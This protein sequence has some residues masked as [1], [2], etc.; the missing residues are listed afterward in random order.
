M[1]ASVVTLGATHQQQCSFQQQRPS[2]CTFAHVR[3]TRGVALV[4]SL[5]SVVNNW[6]SRATG[7]ALQQE[8]CTVQLASRWEAILKGSSLER[9]AECNLATRRVAYNQTNIARSVMATLTDL[10]GCLVAGSSPLSIAGG[11]GA[12]V[13]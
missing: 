9:A 10:L 1:L 8:V 4:G 11:T 2:A 13:L 3:A 6:W 5:A 12:L 7:S